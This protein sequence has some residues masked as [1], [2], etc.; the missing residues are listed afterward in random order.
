MSADEAGKKP[1]N[2]DPEKLLKLEEV[3]E[4]VNDSLPPQEESAPERHPRSSSSYSA[5]RKIGSESGNSSSR[6][7]QGAFDPNS[8]VPDH[9]RG[10]RDQLNIIHQ[11]FHSRDV[12]KIQRKHVLQLTQELFEYQLKDMQHLLTLGMDVQKKTRFVQYLNATKSLQNRIQKESAEAM[13]A[14]MN[15]M[16]DNRL[17]AYAEKNKRDKQLDDLYQRGEIDKKQFDRTKTDNDVMTDEQEQRLRQTADMLITRH[18]EF[19]F[20]TLELFKAKLIQS[21]ML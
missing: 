12:Q 13:L 4:Q 11:Y 5:P 6:I 3:G 19:L 2:I 15:T 10:T 8:T 9:I 1:D 14:V 20:Q 17:D 18:S 16:F 21:D 7:M